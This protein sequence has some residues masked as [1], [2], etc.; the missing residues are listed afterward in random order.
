MT[1]KQIIERLTREL[2]EATKPKWISVSDRM[3]EYNGAIGCNLGDSIIVDIY[4]KGERWTDCYYSF[5]DDC[6]YDCDLHCTITETTHWMYI[7]P[8]PEVK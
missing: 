6:W 1:D 7:P 8:A 5:D 3:P 4:V 2:E